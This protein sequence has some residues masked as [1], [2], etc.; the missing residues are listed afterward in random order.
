MFE[1]LFGADMPLAV[2]FFAAFIIVLALIGAAA[3]AVRRFGA[4]RLGANAA[5]GRQPRLAVI[6]AAAV[7][8]RRRLVLIRRDNVEHL[9][10]IG[11]PTDI[12]VEPNIVRANAVQREAPAARPATE[13]PART[14]PENGQWPLQP[15][16]EPVVAPRPHRPAPPPVEDTVPWPL[17]SQPEP[18]PRP[19]RNVETLSGLAD[20][21]S[22]RPAPPREHAA[23]AREHAGPVARPARSP[24][25]RLAEPRL[26]EPRAPAP[27]PAPAPAGNEAF[28]AA[29][30][31]LADMAHRLEAALRRPTPPTEPRPAPPGD[32]RPPRPVV[33]PVAGMD[34]LAPPPPTPYSAPPEPK[35]EPPESKQAPSKSLYD[36]LEQ[37]MANL[38]GRP[39]GKT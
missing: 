21:L 22:V 19:Q 29:E 18:P 8:G 27:P 6:D 7:D 28:A 32:A 11:G 12:V 14:L 26:A 20:Q 33:D 10:M 16:P 34:P 35:H 5:R 25:P 30:K 13:A 23:P 15:Q 9:L 31:N 24:E 1:T 2:R 3:W 36:S 37:E 17:P 38:L 4:N 39:P